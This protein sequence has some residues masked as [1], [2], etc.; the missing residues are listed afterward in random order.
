MFLRENLETTGKLGNN[1]ETW[2]QRGNLE[3]T[4]KLEKR[5]KLGKRGKRGKMAWE[6][7]PIEIKVKKDKPKAFCTCGL[8]N[9]APFCDGSHA[10]TNYEPNI[11]HFDEDKTILACG[12]LKSKK[13]PICDGSHNG[14][15]D[16]NTDKQQNNQIHNNPIE[17]NVDYIREL[18]LHGLSKSGHHGKM[19]AM[20]VPYYDLPKWEDIQILTAQ[21]AKL[22][23]LEDDEVISETII[24]PNAK[25]PLKLKIPLIIA[26]MSYGALSME[27][28]VALSR[29]AQIQGA[30]VCS[31]EG[32]MLLEEKNENERYFYQLASGKFGFSMD[33][34]KTCQAFHFK[35]GQAAKTGIGGHL[36]AEKVNA[37]IAETRG[38]KQGQSAISPPRFTE[39][40]TTAQIKQF[41]HEV[42]Q[43]TGGIPIGYK[44]SAQ[45]IEKDIEAAIE[46]GVDYIILDGR[47]G[48]TGAAPAIFRD[49]ISI[50]TIPALARAVRY[51]KKKNK[52]ISLIITGG[53]RTPQDFVKALAMGADAIAISNSALQAIGCVGMRI[54][55]LNN[56]PVG[57][58]T[59]NKNLT[60]L[61]NVDK[62]AI[63]LANF[64]GA[65]VELMKLLARAC[66]HNDLREFNINDLT[67]AKSE[68]SKLSGV[69][70]SGIQN[71]DDV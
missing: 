18:A 54:C 48:G 40:E 68:M 39:W 49:N 59:Q 62:E 70:F 1:G 46:I 31:G 65:T 23:L 52:N 30:G 6:N 4:G 28:K 13:M 22:P 20:G 34:V 56:C 67:T 27:A 55:N 38:L 63:N 37:K 15:N 60:K 19:T 11:V 21:L 32:G 71:L 44:L 43:Q 29:G 3:T 51:L 26:D 50:P 58:A 17:P 9:I 42:K 24:G 69:A 45:H 61:L 5:G 57:I 47:G 33:K 16:E 25:K 7:K 66:G 14:I 2:K 8:S 12:C 64:L 53:L 10:G 41:A 35:G 36:P